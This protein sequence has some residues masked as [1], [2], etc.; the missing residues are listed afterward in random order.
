MD[1]DAKIVICEK[2]Q[3]KCPF[4]ALILESPI[5][6]WCCV[7]NHPRKCISQK[8]FQDLNKQRAEQRKLLCPYCKNNI[9]G[10]RE[11]PQNEIFEIINLTLGHVDHVYSDDENY[12]YDFEC[13]LKLEITSKFD[14]P[15]PIPLPTPLPFSREKT[16]T[17]MPKKT[18]LEA[19]RAN[20]IN[21][22]RKII[23]ARLGIHKRACESKSP[24]VIDID[25]EEFWILVLDSFNQKFVNS[26]TS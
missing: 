22:D 7:Y 9:F 12:Y 8:S 4:S 20:K 25:L 5:V 1:V 15:K 13:N 14:P 16:K 24:S 3:L 11:I 23:K 10:Q 26:N 18:D 2:I 19:K 21:V 17:I 6:P